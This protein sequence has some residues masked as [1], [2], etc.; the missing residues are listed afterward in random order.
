MA[1]HVV[2]DAGPLVALLRRDDEHHEKCR[3]AA[4]QL[5]GPL[6]TTW[7]LRNVPNGVVRLLE[8]VSKGLVVCQHMEPIAAEWLTH[9]VQQYDDLRPQL[10]DASLV[11]LAERLDTDIIFTL[12]RRDFTVFRNQHGRP[13]RLVPAALK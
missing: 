3:E 1:E 11:Y 12:D 8:F 6:F 13:F 10:A 2:V 9:F 5:P 7:L 4:A